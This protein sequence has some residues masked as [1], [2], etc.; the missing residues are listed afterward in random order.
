MS[1]LAEPKQLDLAIEIAVDA[2]RGVSDKARIPYITHV[3]RVMAR[4]QM[5]GKYTIGDL[6]VA[7]L[8][9]VIEDTELT[10]QDLIAKG[11]DPW[12]VAGIER[13]SR[14]KGMPYKDYI[15]SLEKEPY[16]KVKIADLEDNMDA[17]RHALAAAWGKDTTS[18]MKRYS[19]ALAFLSGLLP[20]KKYKEG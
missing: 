16:L 20:L 11:I 5:A 13:L 18:L 10:A 12:H 3:M 9:D 19:P 7:V 6:I 1:Q 8:H 4:V 14:P 2:H 17:K 15:I